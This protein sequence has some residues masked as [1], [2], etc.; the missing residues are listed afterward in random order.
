MI[1]GITASSRNA[2]ASSG[3][4]FRSASTA[5]STS[6]SFN[7]SAPTGTSLGD[8]LLLTVWINFD[9]KAGTYGTESYAGWTQHIRSGQFSG[10]GVYLSI[11]SKTA[12]AS[13]S[14]FTWSGGSNWI[15]GLA[16]I[17]SISGATSID[18]VGTSGTSNPASSI[19]TTANNDIL[20]GFFPAWGPALS[21]GTEITLPGSMTTRVSLKSSAGTDANLS[22]GTEKLT[23]SGATG[24]RS[25][26]I[27]NSPYYF[28]PV[29]FGIK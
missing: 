25:A 5:T 23:T 19:T 14:S 10:D 24:T 13:E 6:N 20:L 1:L 22:I 12:G 16:S 3:P 26:T 11:F 15:H 7:I 27:N 18:V 9:P 28:W 4:E 8:L 21:G 17:V 29:L 2:V